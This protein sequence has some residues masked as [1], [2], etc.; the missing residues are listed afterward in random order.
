[1]DLQ[2]V[3]QAYAGL[4]MIRDIV[5]GGGRAMGTLLTQQDVEEYEKMGEIAN[6]LIGR[7]MDESDKL[8]EFAGK[9]Q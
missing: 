1:M 3:G 6:R 7:L 8:R 4:C 9:K 2:L 5:H